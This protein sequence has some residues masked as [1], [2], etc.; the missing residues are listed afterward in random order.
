M[1]EYLANCIEKEGPHHV[2]RFKCKVT[3]DGKTYDSPEYFRTLKDAENAAA[4]VL[5]IIFSFLI[6]YLNSSVVYLVLMIK[7]VNTSTTIRLLLI[8]NR[9]E[10]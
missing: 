1:H 5:L 8:T 7:R 3:I 9:S 4:R 2:I 6:S 10:V